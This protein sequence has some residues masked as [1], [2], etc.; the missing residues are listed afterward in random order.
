MSAITKKV[1]PSI[2]GA[3]IRFPEN[4][5]HILAQEGEEVPL[6]KFWSRRLRGGDVVEVLDKVFTKK[7]KEKAE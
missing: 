7:S 2:L 4:M 1:K 5:T 6:D 3:V